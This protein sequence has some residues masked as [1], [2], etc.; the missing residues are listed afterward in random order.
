MAY[1]LT[2]LQQLLF[3]KEQTYATSHNG[4]CVQQ[5]CFM[6]SVTN[7]KRFGGGFLIAPNAVPTDQLLD[8]IIIEE[9]PVHM[10]LRYLPV[11]QQGKHLDLPFVHTLQT[12]AI[13]IQA[14]GIV[15]AHIDGEFLAADTFTIQLLPK[16]F[17]FLW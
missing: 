14:T 12:G 5:N 16:R 2:V 15:P 8:A 6:I 1:L 17:P 4:K 3:Y 13:A 11:L 7:G 10:R 9:L